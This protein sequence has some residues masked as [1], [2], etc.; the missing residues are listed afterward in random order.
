[1]LG[2]EVEVEFSSEEE[3]ADDA[4]WGEGYTMKMGE[5]RRKN[6]PLVRLFTVCRMSP[7]MPKP[8]SRS[9]GEE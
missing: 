3:Q 2:E 6:L 4:G 5:K 9:L 1:V 7:A 8:M